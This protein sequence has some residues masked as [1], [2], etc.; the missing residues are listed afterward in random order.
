MAG[1]GGDIL[2]KKLRWRC[3]RGTREL[4]VLLSKFL[5]NHFQ[6]LDPAL[7]SAFQT[8]LDSEDDQ[9]WDWLTGRRQVADKQLRDI[10]NVI[11]RAS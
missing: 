11:R 7:Q 8:L 3:R 2:L 10:V 5:A 6:A 1:D 4:D 9:L